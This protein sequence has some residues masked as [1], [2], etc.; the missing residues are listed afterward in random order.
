MVPPTAGPPGKLGVHVHGLIL[1]LHSSPYTLAMNAATLNFA[2]EQSSRRGLAGSVAYLFALPYVA[3][4]EEREE[5]LRMQPLPRPAGV[6]DD[7]E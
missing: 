6:C 4:L 1:S 3:S 7:L 5:L 2:W